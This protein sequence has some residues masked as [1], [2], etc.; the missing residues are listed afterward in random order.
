MTPESL[1]GAF[2]LFDR[3]VVMVRSLAGDTPPPLPEGQGRKF[4]PLGVIPDQDAYA[5]QWDALNSPPAPTTT[6]TE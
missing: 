6:R 3:F 4:S 2:A 1:L 5:A